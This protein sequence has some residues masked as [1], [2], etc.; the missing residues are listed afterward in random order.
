MS[1]YCHFFAIFISHQKTNFISS[2]TVYSHQSSNQGPDYNACSSN[3][4][5]FL[6]IKNTPI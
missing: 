4:E 1:T 5:M 6:S 3:P 2:S